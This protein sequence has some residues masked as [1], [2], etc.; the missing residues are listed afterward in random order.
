MVSIARAL[1]QIKDDLGQVFD[2]RQIERVCREEGYRWRHGKLTPTV[3]IRW[4]L[5]Q[6]LFGNAACEHVS[7]LAGRDFSGSAFCQA[8]RRLPVGILKQLLR[9]FIDT[10]VTSTK[11]MAT[12]HGHRT[13]LVDGSSCSM[14]DEPALVK[15]FGYVN[16][17]QRRRLMA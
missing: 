12:W 2:G 17:R 8:R 6:V 3:T 7:Q 5:I 15:H 13:F 11:S 9:S 14:P 10:A 1:C 16:A 4:F